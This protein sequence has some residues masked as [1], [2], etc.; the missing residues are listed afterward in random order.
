MNNQIN[1]QEELVQRINVNSVCEIFR[2]LD[3]IQ[4]IYT[5]SLSG[6]QI[7]TAEILQELFA[8]HALMTEIVES[9]LYEFK[10]CIEDG[11]KLFEVILRCSTINSEYFDKRLLRDIASIV[12]KFELSFR[13]EISVQLIYIA[14]EKGC[15][16]VNKL[17]ENPQL[18]MPSDLIKEVPEA[19]NDLIKCVGCFIASLPE[20]CIFHLMKVL[21]ILVIRLYTKLNIQSEKEMHGIGT[22]ISAIDNHYQKDSKSRLIS[23]LRSINTNVRNPIIH[24]EAKDVTIEDAQRIIGSTNEVVDLLLKE[25]RGENDQV[26][27]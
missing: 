12:Y 6:T 14:T 16:D 18:L 23:M 4:R 22:Y 24:P 26:Q 1:K 7:T 9:K 5:K 11:T 15:Y 17:S 2:Y 19:A 25:L 20:A 27:E 21:E 3:S 10:T 13:N 8:L